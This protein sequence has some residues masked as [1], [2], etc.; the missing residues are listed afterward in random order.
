MTRFRFWQQ[1]LFCTS[2]LFAGF[3]L[4]F[5]VYGNNPLFRP[6]NDALAHR[7]WN[8]GQLPAQ[9]NQFRA[10]IWGSLG[11]TIACS[12]ILLAYIA[13]NSFFRKERWSYYAI[14]A[15]FGTWVIIDT[16]ICFSYKVYF[17]AYLINAFSFIVKA[18]PL[19]FI[20]KYF[21]DKNYRM[22]NTIP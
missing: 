9:A 12:Y 17:Q 4:V 16:V 14:S 5:A 15:A 6:Y 10:F 22:L 11:G 2:L 7:F 19:A 8:M 20:W 13:Y 3:G 1:W 21:F 18:L